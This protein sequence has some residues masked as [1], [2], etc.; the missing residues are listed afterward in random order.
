MSKFVSIASP[1][2]FVPRNDVL[3]LHHRSCVDFDNGHQ[4]LVLKK[5][6][7]EAIRVNG[8]EIVRYENKTPCD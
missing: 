4:L 2:E 5:P 8:L 7:G 3:Q 6:L 1:Y